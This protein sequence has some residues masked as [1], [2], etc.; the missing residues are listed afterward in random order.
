MPPFSVQPRPVS[1]AWIPS[2][3]QGLGGAF[4]SRLLTPMRCNA[5]HSELLLLCALLVSRQR[6]GSMEDRT[7]PNANQRMKIWIYQAL[8]EFWFRIQHSCS[9]FP[10]Q[11][12]G[13][14]RS[15]PADGADCRTLL[16]LTGISGRVR[17]QPRVPDVLPLTWRTPLRR[18]SS[19]LDKGA[20]LFP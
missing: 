15:P 8:W 11:L 20:C 13:Y 18:T 9:A 1:F 5:N 17:I 4:C 12:A 6:C 14:Y 2:H 3:P 16:I 19:V 10:P 7:F